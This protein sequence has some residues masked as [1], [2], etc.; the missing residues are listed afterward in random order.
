MILE[1]VVANTLVGAYR[2]IKMDEKA[3]NKYTQAY[4]KREKAKFLVNE[5][6]EKTDKRLMNVVKKKRAIKEFLIPRFAEVY[7][8]IRELEFENS[9]VI[10]EVILGKNNTEK[11]L[12]LDEM[13]KVSKKN[14]SDK[15]YLCGMMIYGM[16]GMMAKDSKQFMSAANNQMRI[17]NVQYSQAESIIEVLD[18]IEKR[19][20]KIA[21]VLA[22]FNYLL[23]TALDEVEKIIDAYGNNF[24]LYSDYEIGAV[25][26]CENIVIGL[27]EIFDMPVINENGELVE[28]A[29]KIII[30]SEQFIEQMKETL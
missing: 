19:A 24:Y 27:S 7:Q 22:A 6:A 2:S 11:R 4:E 18:A 23:S 30:N 21:S 20:D 25:M 16:G 9:S 5:K 17:A 15:E 8:V 10:N 14:Y 1:Y 3:L 13:T 29:E 12:I 26:T 28:E